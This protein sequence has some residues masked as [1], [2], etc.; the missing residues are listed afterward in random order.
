[1]AGG[2]QPSGRRVRRAAKAATC[3]IVG[4]TL[5][6]SF[7]AVSPSASG[8]ASPADRY[9]ALG[10][11]Y[12]SGLGMPAQVPAICGT[13]SSLSYPHLVAQQLGLD[14]SAF[15]DASCPGASTQGVTSLQLPHLDA[16]TTLVTMT[17]GGDNTGIF[18]SVITCTTMNPNTSVCGQAWLDS[19]FAPAVAA[20][21]PDLAQLLQAI[22]QRAPQALVLLVN[23]LAIHPQQGAGCYPASPTDPGNRFAYADIPYL[24]QSEVI[25]NTMLAE[26][27]AANGAILV[28][29]YSLSV[30]HDSCEA[31][32]VRWVEP[33][34]NGVGA[35]PLHPNAAGHEAVSVAVLQAIQDARR[36]APVPAPQVERT[37]TFA[38]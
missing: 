35:S 10:D 17:V 7:G 38:G 13:N 31:E 33:E 16:S 30:E 14:A 6:M 37:P 36:A 28:D 21:A 29:A 18:S 27:A 26:Q 23:Y 34:V 3:M 2:A 15:F 12:T 20:A 1:M 11:S 9:V 25:L 5:A 19:Q 8:S 4:L 24:R 32:G 22:H